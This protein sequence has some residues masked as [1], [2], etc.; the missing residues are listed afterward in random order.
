MQERTKRL[1]EEVRQKEQAA[2]L[3]RKERMV[4]AREKARKFS[5]ASNTATLPCS[6]SIGG[7]SNLAAEIDDVESKLG[8]PPD[9][10]EDWRR[11]YLKFFE[12]HVESVVQGE[13]PT[14]KPAF[15]SYAASIENLRRRA[16]EI[17]G[18]TMHRVDEK[19]IGAIRLR[20]RQLCFMA[21]NFDNSLGE[22]SV[23]A[24]GPPSTFGFYIADMQEQRCIWQKV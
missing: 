16:E 14:L 7:Q 9:A 23:M 8:F 22:F 2:E 6:V 5:G 15:T 24:D 4:R 10:I 11:F 1:E 19:G 17:L 3:R 21:Q 20:A 13:W 12:D 18:E